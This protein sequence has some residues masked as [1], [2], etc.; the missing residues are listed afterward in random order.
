MLISTKG[1]YALRYMVDLVR[2]TETPVSLGDSAARLGISMKYLEQIAANLV[3]EGHITALRGASGGYRLK[4]TADSYTVLSI[5]QSVENH[6]STVSCI[7][8]DPMLCERADDCP[9]LPLYKRLQRAIDEILES[10]TLADLAK[11]HEKSV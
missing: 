8:H 1:R 3:K 7:A 11:S 6:L 2:H 10:T 9:T 4:R 5:L